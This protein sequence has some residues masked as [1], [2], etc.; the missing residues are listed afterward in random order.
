MQKA[1]KKLKGAFRAHGVG[2]GAEMTQVQGEAFKDLLQVAKRLLA[3]EQKT[4]DKLYSMHIYCISKA[5]LVAHYKQT[6]I[7]SSFRKT[8][9]WGVSRKKLFI[10]LHLFGYS[11]QNT[12]LHFANDKRYLFSLCVYSI[13]GNSS[14]FFYRKDFIVE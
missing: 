2:C 1:V 4:V 10:V 8:V 6:L 13:F 5:S 3:Q 9:L 11:K 7:L 12:E 14:R